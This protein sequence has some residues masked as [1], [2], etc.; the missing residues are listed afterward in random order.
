MRQF[1]LSPFLNAAILVCAILLG[2]NVYAAG[3]PP[4]TNINNTVTIDYEV[5]AV[6]QPSVSS[7]TTSFVVD[8]KINLTVTTLD[9][10]EVGAGAGQLA[11]VT[12]Y[13]VTNLSNSAQDYALASTLAGIANPFG[14]GPDTF[15][16]T[17]CSIHV[18]DGG[19]VGYQ[20]GQDLATFIDELAPDVSK[21]VYLVCDI[22]AS[23]LT[24]QVSAVALTA[25]TRAGG[26]V[27]LGSVLTQT[28]A[29]T[30][31][32]DVVFADTQVPLVGTSDALLDAAASAANAYKIGL[33]VILTKS[34][35]CTPT[36]AC[37]NNFKPGDTVTYQILVN[38]TG[39]GTANNLVVSD[40]IPNNLTYLPASIKINAAARTDPADADNASF[41][42]NAINVNFGNVVAPQTF[43][44][45]FKA[46]VN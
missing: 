19:S 41:I 8:N 23:A 32:I 3:T 17:A 14:G 16:P 31:G 42:T 29:P 1:S 22:P 44:L 18:E 21:T 24:N 45:Q 2:A 39:A 43:N 5:D 26:G 10:A 27:G 4:G 37:T 33:S 11:A 38:V 30:A 12:R 35:L 15:N 28:A 20:A 36:P 13:L 40:S 34:V 25:N 9:T 46:V 6:P 7:N